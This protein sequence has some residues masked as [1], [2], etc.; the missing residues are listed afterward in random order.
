MIKTLGIL[1]G[2]IFVGAIAAEVIRKKCPPETLENLRARICGITSSVK[3]AF[4]SGYAAAI[5]ESPQ[6]AEPGV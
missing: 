1:I 5:M 4:K 2:G 3:D 6:A